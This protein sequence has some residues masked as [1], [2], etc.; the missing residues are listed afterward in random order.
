MKRLFISQPMKG[1]TDEEIRRTRKDAINTA[2]NMVNDEVNVIESFSEDF[3]TSKPLWFLGK[4][5]ELLS[6]A[7]FIFFCDGWQDA[8]G[9]KIEHECAEAYGIPIIRD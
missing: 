8:R 9:C 2:A 5:L 3:P 6:S 4:A 1:K 7:D